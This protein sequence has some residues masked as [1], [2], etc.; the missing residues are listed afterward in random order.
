M[1]VFTSTARTADVCAA[2]NERLNPRDEYIVA[3]H[4]AGSRCLGA[5]NSGGSAKP[6]GNGLRSITG[7]GDLRET[8]G[9]IHNTWLEN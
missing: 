5:T 8:E 9:L 6:G 4:V 1:P 7:K 3:I 2:R